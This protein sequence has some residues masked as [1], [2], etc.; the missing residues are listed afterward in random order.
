MAGA[1]EVL[2]LSDDDEDTPCF[3]TQPRSRRGSQQDT[4]ITP[5]ELLKFCI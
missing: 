4:P 2:A 5:G 1:A 3:K